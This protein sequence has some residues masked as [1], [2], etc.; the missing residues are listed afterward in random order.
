MPTDNLKRA[1]R[2]HAKDRGLSYTA[3]LREIQG[4]E[5]R[6]LRIGETHIA[7]GENILVIGGAGS[8]Y[9]A[10]LSHL[11]GEG[12]RNG[13]RVVQV[14]DPRL[15]LD[16]RRRGVETVQDTADDLSCLAGIAPGTAERP[17]M[18]VVPQ[19]EPRH[20]SA[21]L[22]QV[23]AGAHTSLVMS[24]HR[25]SPSLHLP[26]FG[27]RL[28]VGA[29]PE[30]VEVAFFGRV[31]GTGDQRRAGELPRGAGWVI[32]GRGRPAERFA[33]VPAGPAISPCEAGSG[34]DGSLRGR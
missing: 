28:G 8:G 10:V 1:V 14:L 31:L 24:S 3:A 17:L 33:P 18:I 4:A 16:P 15:G 25:P 5:H 12:V 29:L 19:P 7:A 22:S 23:A 34:P 9:T 27:A 6:R 11:V 30:H 20:F 13:F 26:V 32:P 2:A 21:R